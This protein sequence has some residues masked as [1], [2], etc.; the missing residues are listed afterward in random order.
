MKL[1]SQH[2]Q[3]E[4]EL[5]EKKQKFKS[6][7]A[8]HQQQSQL[9]YESELTSYRQQAEA[10]FKGQIEQVVSRLAEEHYA[11]VKRGQQKNE[12]LVQDNLKLG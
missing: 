10:K 2:Q 11:E 4:A 8:A 6:K 9:R 12:K 3:F 5:Y 1:Q 7:L